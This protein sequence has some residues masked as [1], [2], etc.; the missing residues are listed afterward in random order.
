LL[1]LVYVELCIIAYSLGEPTRWAN[2]LICRIM[3]NVDM[4]NYANSHTRWVSATRWASMSQW[5]S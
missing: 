1:K 3:Q 5:F 2:K 4:Q